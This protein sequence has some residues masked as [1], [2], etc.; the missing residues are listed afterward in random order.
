MFTDLI[1]VIGKKIGFPLFFLSLENGKIFFVVVI[2]N[3]G[4]YSASK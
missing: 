2:N 4:E 3:N 1:F